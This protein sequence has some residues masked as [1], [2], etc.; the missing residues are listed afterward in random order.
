MTES[1]GLVTIPFSFDAQYCRSARPARLHI[2]QNLVPTA[3]AGSDP[4]HQMNENYSI[5]PQ[6]AGLVTVRLLH[7]ADGKCFVQ[8][9][10][11]TTGDTR[12]QFFATTCSPTPP[13]PPPTHSTSPTPTST[14]T[15]TISPSPS[16][17]Q[18][19]LSVNSTRPITPTALPVGRAVQSSSSSGG[20]LA[21]TGSRTVLPA[22]VGSLLLIAGAWLMNSNRRPRRH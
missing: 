7:G 4:V 2:H 12:G 14:Q 8:V 13:P 1:G 18:S 20:S 16:T 15:V 3:H 11:R 22:G 19:A 21:T 6:D 17:T 9:D 10:A 5:G